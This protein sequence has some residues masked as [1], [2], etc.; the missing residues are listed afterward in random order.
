MFSLVRASAIG[1]FLVSAAEALSVDVQVPSV[2]RDLQ[3]ALHTHMFKI[4]STF[5]VKTSKSAAPD[6][7]F[8]PIFMYT[9]VFA[10][11]QPPARQVTL[12][13][14]NYLSAGYVYVQL[15]NGK[16]DTQC[17]K[18]GVTAGVPVNTCIAADSSSYKVQ[19]Q[20]G[21]LLATWI[22]LGTIVIGS[23]AYRLIFVF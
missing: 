21:N 6:A 9:C 19:L 13:T 4:L 11:A 20:T 23:G 14:A 18:N 10:D 15:S 3:T 16:T 22:Y 8:Q 5:P 17:E 12:L 2:E 7:T 1:L